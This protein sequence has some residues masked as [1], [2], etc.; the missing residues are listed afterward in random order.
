MF[1][2]LFTKKEK[3]K[4][5]PE[6]IETKQILSNSEI[7]LPVDYTIYTPI[8]YKVDEQVSRIHSKLVAEMHEYFNNTNIDKGNA[9]YLDEWLDKQYRKVNAQINLERAEHRQTLHKLTRNYTTQKS[10]GMQIEQSLEKEFDSFEEKEKEIKN[11]L[12]K[13]EEM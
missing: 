6:T 1:K 3:H 11:R 2:K 12:D 7:P 13:L 10:S 9:D 5:Y 8:D 4:G